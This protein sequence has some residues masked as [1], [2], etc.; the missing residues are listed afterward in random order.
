MAAHDSVTVRQYIESRFS[1]T[2]LDM[3]T[4]CLDRRF[5]SSRSASIISKVLKLVIEIITQSSPRY[6]ECF[7]LLDVFKTRCYIIPQ[8]SQQ[9]KDMI[10]LL[11]SFKSDLPS[12]KV[13]PD[14]ASL[15]KFKKYIVFDGVTDKISDKFK[16]IDSWVGD[17]RP[18]TIKVYSY[19]TDKKFWKKFDIEF[20]GLNIW[21]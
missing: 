10:I 7:Y 15:M 12:A 21:S 18:T 1:N 13:V 17:V 16:T 11:N 5:I 4:E 6:Y 8:H 20:V 2:E 9:I 3:I 19:L 14:L